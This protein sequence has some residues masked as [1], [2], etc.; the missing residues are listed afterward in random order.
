MAFFSWSTSLGKILTIDNLCKR[1]IIVLDWCYMFK[2]CG[3]SVHHL[4]LHCP[5]AFELW[6]LVFCLFGLHWVMPH[7][8]LIFLSLG[9]VNSGDIAIW[10]FGDLCRIT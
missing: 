10:V 1:R 5:I 7:L 6:S 3:E 8:V 2:R 9:K 4:L